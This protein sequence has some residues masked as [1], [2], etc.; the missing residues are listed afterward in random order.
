MT[1]D[2]TGLSRIAVAAQENLL[3]TSYSKV[4]GYIIKFS[5][6]GT[7][8]IFKVL[9]ISRIATLSYPAKAVADDIFACR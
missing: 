4:V 1:V 9:D 2:H 3:S 7:P 6:P 5:Q 8:N